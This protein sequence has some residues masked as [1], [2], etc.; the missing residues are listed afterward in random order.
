MNSITLKTSVS[1]SNSD[2]IPL[3]DNIKGLMIILVVV[4]HIADFNYTGTY[5]SIFLFIY[6]FHM[7]MMFF[8]SGLFFHSKNLKRKILYF[9]SIGFASKILVWITLY[10]VS[11]EAPGFLLLSDSFLPW[12]MFVLAEYLA[13]MNLLKKVN[14]WFLFFGAILL[15]CLVG[16][17]S[18]VGDYLYLSRMLVFFPFYLMGFILR[19]K[20]DD[21]IR[22]K[23]RFRIPLSILSAILLLGYLAVCLW[24]PET[25][26]IIRHLLTGRNP[27]SEQ[28]LP[29]GFLM[30]LRCY[31]IA[32]VMMASIV[33]LMPNRKIPLLT[34]IGTKTLNIYFWHWPI[35]KLSWEF[36]SL[37]ALLELGKAGKIG[38]LCIGVVLSIGL[39]YIK[40]F[41]FPMKQIQT[42]C[43]KEWKS[44]KK[45]NTDK[46]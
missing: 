10:I 29:Y 36:L 45:D 33:F 3:W 31:G 40:F 14:Q 12:F 23:N 15:V 38:L 28:I 20:K 8:V 13:L 21:I 25:V 32:F 41:D 27:Y 11:G 44:T 18:A 46:G 16:Y 30:R 6:S 7:P 35:I 1:N 37:G 5:K 26:G 43:F 24:K 9:I 22:F 2:R 17:D 39:A 4:G 42:I 19:E 34:K